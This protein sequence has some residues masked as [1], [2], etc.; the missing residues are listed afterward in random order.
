MIVEKVF[1]IIKTEP[2]KY[3]FS[4]KGFDCFII[5]HPDDGN[6]MGYVAITKLSPLVF[7]NGIEY[8]DIECHGGITYFGYTLKWWNIKKQKN[9]IRWL[10]FDCGNGNDFKPFLMNMIE[11]LINKTSVARDMVEMGLNTYKDLEYVIKECKSIVNQ[12]LDY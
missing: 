7:Y 6:Y 10:G 11:K 5:R 12:I 8:V 2:Y 9:N 1:E 4:Y 3:R